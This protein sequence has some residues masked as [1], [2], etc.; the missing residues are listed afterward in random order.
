MTASAAAT[1]ATLATATAR[2][3]SAAGDQ[4]CAYQSANVNVFHREPE[5]RTKSGGSG[6]SYVQIQNPGARP[7]S[8]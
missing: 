3:V 8:I 7:R 2:I 1:L 4:N 6:S 5:L